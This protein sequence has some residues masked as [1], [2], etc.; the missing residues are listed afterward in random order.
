ME[1]GDHVEKPIGV[2]RREHW[3]QV[4]TDQRT[5]GMGAAAFC[6][7][8][9]I[10][11]WQMSY[12]RKALGAGAKRTGT[13]DSSFVELK[14]GLVGAGIVVEAGRWRVRVEPGFDAAT[15]LRTLEA[16]AAP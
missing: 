15:L 10:A 11:A 12:W 4:L 7:A 16:L 9:G 2:E 3:R 13:E 8:R 14:S 6:R 1:A 5:S